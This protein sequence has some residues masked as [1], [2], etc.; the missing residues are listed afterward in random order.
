MSIFTISKNRI[1]EILKH[2]K[3]DI[4]NL[5]EIREYSDFV[6]EHFLMSVSM[7][8]EYIIRKTLEGDETPFDENEILFLNL[9]KI[10]EWWVVSE[11][12]QYWLTQ[13]NEIIVNGVWGRQ[14]T[15]QAIKCDGIIQ[16][17]FIDL[18]HDRLNY[19]T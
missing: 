8:W 15:G 17:I 6:E 1:K 2:A 10:Y 19:L 9:Q 16:E 14:I 11:R 12:M 4:D 18:L 5:L 13:N 7:E 3:K